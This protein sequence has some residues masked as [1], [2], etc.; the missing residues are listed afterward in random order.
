MVNKLFY[1][2]DKEIYIHFNMKIVGLGPYRQLKEKSP[3]MKITLAQ[4]T[5]GN[6]PKNHHTVGHLA[7]FI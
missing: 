3:E 2:H 1:G 6:S 4:N 5:F 7:Q